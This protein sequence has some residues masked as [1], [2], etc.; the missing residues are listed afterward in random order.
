MNPLDELMAQYEQGLDDLP[1]LFF[2]DENDNPATGIDLAIFLLWAYSRSLLEE[3]LAARISNSR[4]DA[5]CPFADLVR[6]AR[7]ALGD[8]FR[9]SNFNENGRPFALK[10]LRPG[11]D[12]RY[13]LDLDGL[14]PDEKTYA[15][16]PDTQNSIDRVFAVLD[17]RRDGFQK[18]SGAG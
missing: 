11:W 7:A 4:F 16:I 13:H 12:Y 15:D 5:S 9:P 1:I 8:G 2:A 18:V 6:D 14:F 17:M 3:E 10:Y